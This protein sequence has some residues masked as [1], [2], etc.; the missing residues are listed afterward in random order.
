[1]TTP[2]F[3]FNWQDL[4]SDVL[5]QRPELAFLGKLSQAG[6]SRGMQD[7]YR[8]RT[9]DFLSQFQGRLAQQLMGAGPGFDPNSLTKPEDF[10][11]GIN[12]QQ[13]FLSRPPQERGFFSSQ[14]APKTRYLFR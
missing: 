13:D 6:G 5:G 1:M 2:G 8:R 9:G 12:F 10:F 4:T 14:Y 3:P 7:F 11:G